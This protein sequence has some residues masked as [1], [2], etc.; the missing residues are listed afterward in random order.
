MLKGYADIIYA[1]ELIGDTI[2]SSLDKPHSPFVKQPYA[3][4]QS[5]LYVAASKT[6]DIGVVNR[7]SRALLAV[8]QDGTFEKILKM[9]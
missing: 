6:T 4:M 5:A 9:Q 8:K 3:G 7:L 2:H 1:N